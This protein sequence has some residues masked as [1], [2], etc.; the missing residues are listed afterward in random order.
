MKKR[1][2]AVVLTIAL[3]LSAFSV[4]SM[5]RKSQD[6]SYKTYAS[7]IE[8]NAQGDFMPAPFEET[9]ATPSVR[10]ENDLLCSMQGDIKPKGW[11]EEEE[12]E[13]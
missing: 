8:C 9:V 3:I 1:F 13:D 2:V 12:E 4:W 5:V 10:N 11:D 7:S 6:N